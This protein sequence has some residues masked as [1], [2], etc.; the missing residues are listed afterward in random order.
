MNF[1]WMLNRATQ[2]V[3][4]H[5]RFQGALARAALDGFASAGGALRQ[6]MREVGVQEP[7]HSACPFDTW[8]AN[9]P[10]SSAPNWTSPGAKGVPSCAQP[11][12]PQWSPWPPGATVSTPHAAAHQA[13]AHQTSAHQAADHAATYAEAKATDPSAAPHLVLEGAPSERIV[14]ALALRN[15]THTTVT[16]RVLY[17]EFK[18]ETGHVVTPPFVLE[19]AEVTLTAGEQTTVRIATVL[20][21][22]MV[23]NASYYG[24]ISLESLPGTRVS[25]VLRARPL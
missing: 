11:G 2:V 13:A 6:Y 23:P 16:A 18:S 4:A 12:T 1:E 21:V 20:P 10:G 7:P 24:E 3:D 14:T 8:K 9:P 17:S 5:L 19:P 15:H 22:E 25:V